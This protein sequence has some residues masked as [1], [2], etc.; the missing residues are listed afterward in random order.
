MVCF[1]IATHNMLNFGTGD[2]NE[3]Y[4]IPSYFVSISVSYLSIPPFDMPVSPAMLYSFLFQISFLV[5][6]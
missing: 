4:H 5:P 6:K 1:L 3:E 2:S